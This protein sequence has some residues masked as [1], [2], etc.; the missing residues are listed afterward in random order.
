MQNVMMGGEA[1]VGDM[2]YSDDSVAAVVAWVAYDVAS[3]VEVVVVA[4]AAFV[5]DDPAEYPA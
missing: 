1:A 3:C 5:V 4:A 2:N